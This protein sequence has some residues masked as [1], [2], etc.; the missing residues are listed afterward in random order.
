MS[1]IL[2]DSKS[3]QQKSAFGEQSVAELTPIIQLQFPY[4]INA[5][6]VEERTNNGTLTVDSNRAKLSTG[7]SANQSAQFV[8]RVPVKYN[9][10]QGGLCR[11]TSVFTTGVAN[12]VQY[13][14][15]GDNSDGYFFGYNGADFGILRRNSGKLEV[16]TL[17]VT[18][19]STTA[20]DI[21]ITLNGVAVTDVTVSD[22]TAT[23]TTTTANEIAAHDYSGVGGGW[24]AHAMGSTVRFDSYPAAS[25]SGTYSLSGASTA[26]GTFAQNII[27]V[28][29]TETVIAQTAWNV[30]MMD[31]TG[32]SG[33]TL[34]PTKGNVYQIRYQWLGYGLITFYIENPATGFLQ[35]VHKIEYANAN[36]IPS[37]DNPT[38]PL[39][40][41]VKN[42]SNTSDV[43]MYT[44]SMGG[45]IEGKKPTP[46]VRHGVSIEAAAIGTDETPI[47]TIHNPII[48]QGLVNRVRSK[49]T[50][51]E[52]SVDGS[53]PSTAR[54][55]SNTSLTGASF[56]DVS[57]N[58][59]PIKVDT[60][61]TVLSGGSLQ[62][63]SGLAKA[64]SRLFQLD[65]TSFEIGPRDFLT[66][67]LEASS[68]TVD[69]V[70]SINWV[71]EF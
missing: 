37:V 53:K 12:S 64:D 18:T 44:P 49:L 63:A 71:D 4:N 48:Y 9:P 41:M 8:S 69:A 39:C 25:L 65:L 45:F 24:R 68:G 36:T 61:A 21:T 16:R 38:L 32:S 43:V 42:T 15:I 31:G 34:D 11:F 3:G 22:A 66:I 27:G 30:D 67:S 19:K 50:F 26:A 60:S 6:L 54:F 14:G 46:V 59:T 35:M 1:V 28:A 17:T 62:F 29:P 33:V 57:T 13:I 70:V 55:R 20:E 10:G 5:Q 2:S 40:A 56:S 58:T 51:I 7:A 52:V 47:L 23:D